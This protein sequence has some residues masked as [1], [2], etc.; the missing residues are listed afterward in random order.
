MK[1]FRNHLMVAALFGALA[2]IGTVMN[3]RQAS[4]QNRNSGGAPVISEA[5]RRGDTAT[6][7]TAINSGADVNS[8][9]ADGNTLLIQ[10]AVY[11]SAADLE[12]LLAHGADVNAANN[13]GHTALMR[14]MP[15][16]VKVKLLVEHGA[17]VNASA[18]G[19]TPLLIA[20]GIRSAEAVLAPAVRKT[21]RYP[22][23]LAFPSWIRTRWLN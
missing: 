2:A 7:R 4:A 5:L 19:T 17:D 15:D 12:F 22:Q 21:V 1:K 14:A 6:V 18:Q 23:L 3:S 11:A 16:F 9:D 8:R 10:A 13:A 20:A